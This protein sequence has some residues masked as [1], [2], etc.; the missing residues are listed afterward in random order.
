MRN[1]ETVTTTISF[2][3]VQALNLDQLLVERGTRRVNSMFIER[4]YEAVE[5]QNV[6][7]QRVFDVLATATGLRLRPESRHE[8]YGNLSELRRQRLLPEGKFSNEDADVLKLVLQATAH[9]QLR[10]RVGDVLWVLHKDARAG[11]QAVADY[12]EDARSIDNPARWPPVVDVLNRAANLAK[13]LG[14]SN[15]QLKEVLDYVEACVRRQGSQDEGL[16]TNRMMRLL[17]A[18][19]HGDPAEYAPLAAQLAQAAEVAQEWHFARE[20]WSVA[21]T[22]H[23]VGGQADSARAASVSEAETYV[24]QTN[25][26][27]SKPSLNL[28]YHMASGYLQQAIEA[29]RRLPETR[30]RVEQLRAQ[31][32][33][34]QQHSVGELIPITEGFDATPLVEQARQAVRG[35]SLAEAFVNLA[36]LA[37]LPSRT[38]LH[39]QALQARQKYLGLQFFANVYVNSLGRVIARQP[40]Q[41]ED[42]L[43]A[44]MF[45]SM[46]LHYQV[47][48]QA[49]I[50]PAVQQLVEEHAVSAID[51][52]NILVHNPLVPADRVHSV[53]R[54]LHAGLYGDFLVAAHLLIPQLENTV[55]SLLAQQGVLTSGLDKDGIQDELNLNSLLVDDKYTEP[56]GRFLGED[57][58]FTLRGTL[59][60]RFG[61]NLRNDMA[62]GLVSDGWYYG[63]IG[64]YFWW[65][66][67]RVYTLPIQLSVL[68]TQVKSQSDGEGGDS[69]PEPEAQP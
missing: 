17:L 20:Y 45:E 68:R 7:A 9:S 39:T 31:L 66:A 64:V 14:K 48:A 4:Y 25:Q 2:A 12:L 46:R 34:V 67:W 6:P 15:P 59:V 13:T 5:Q 41:P 38:A 37:P 35:T 43:L 55:R 8:P 19:G 1:L 22:W 51:I 63:P 3:E 11:R 60:E 16:Y 42:V 21:A 29:L 40:Q 18:F 10:A 49:V 58:V 61:A 65:L 54:G 33:E 53:A 62:H 23:L 30:E 26:A 44:D 32:L 50:Q 28:P 27:L 57:L 24:Q 69:T 36:R 47:I 52:E 56:L